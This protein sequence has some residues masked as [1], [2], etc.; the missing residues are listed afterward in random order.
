MHYRPDLRDLAPEQIIDYPDRRSAGLHPHPFVTVTVDEIVD[1]LLVGIKR[2][3][4]PNFGPGQTL[5]LYGDVFHDMSSPGPPLHPLEKAAPVSYR[6]P[7]FDEGWHHLLDVLSQALYLIRGLDFKISDIHLHEN[8]RITAVVVRA[9]E[10]AHFQYLH[11][12]IPFSTYMPGR[13]T[14]CRRVSGI[15]S[16]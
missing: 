7:V 10:G 14:S 16:P 15:S 1:A 12:N 3:A 4:E 11:N 13:G 6:T 5:E 8:D 9:P 2:L